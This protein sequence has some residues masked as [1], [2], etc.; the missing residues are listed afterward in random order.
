[1][2]ELLVHNTNVFVTD[3]VANSD[4]TIEILYWSSQLISF[5]LI[6]LYS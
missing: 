5:Y 6:A 4:N 2:R 1:M 3:S